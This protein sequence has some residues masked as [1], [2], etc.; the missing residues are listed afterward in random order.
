M[1]AA[2]LVAL[3]AGEVSSPRRDFDSIVPVCRRFE[4]Y[5]GSDALR[6]RGSAHGRSR[7]RR[8]YPVHL[9]AQPPRFHPGRCGFLGLILAA[10]LVAAANCAGRPPHQP[11]QSLAPSSPSAAQTGQAV[12]APANQILSPQPWQVAGLSPAMLFAVPTA[13]PA[14]ASSGSCAARAPPPWLTRYVLAPLIAILVD[15]GIARPIVGARTCLFVVDCRWRPELWLLAP[16]LRPT[17]IPA[18]K[19]LPKIGASAGYRGAS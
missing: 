9:P 14:P 2:V 8:W 11:K 7:G 10:V 4:P 1:S 15:M 13:Q 3:A 19:P 17:M 6:P 18:V 5:L 12:L 16:P